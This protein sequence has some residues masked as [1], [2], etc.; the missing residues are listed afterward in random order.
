[1][2]RIRH[3]TYKC[4]ASASLHPA[5]L[6]TNLQSRLKLTITPSRCV[7]PHVYAPPVT[8]RCYWWRTE[9]VYIHSHAYSKACS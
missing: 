5:V 2:N 9:Q 1:M 4:Q 3:T 7:T 6:P 8:G